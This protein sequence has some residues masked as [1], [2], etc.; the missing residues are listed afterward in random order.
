VLDG[1]VRRESIRQARPGADAPLVG[2]VRD[3]VEISEGVVDAGRQPGAICVRPRC[4][5]PDQAPLID[6]CE[7]DAIEVDVEVCL[8]DKQSTHELVID[9]EVDEA[10][11]PEGFRIVR[12]DAH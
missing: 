3:R 7:G 10:I 8:G 6:G 5:E 11:D 12:V 4:D 2:R 9:V 1:A